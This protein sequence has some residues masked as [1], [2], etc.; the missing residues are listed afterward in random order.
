MKGVF[1]AREM[2]WHYS[3]GRHLDSHSLAHVRHIE[4]Y[5]SCAGYPNDQVNRLTFQRNVHRD[6]TVVQQWTRLLQ[7]HQCVSNISST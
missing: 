4:N 3:N 6:V 1:I 7:T 5:A 2:S